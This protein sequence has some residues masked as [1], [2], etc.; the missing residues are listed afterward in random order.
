MKLSC[1]IKMSDVFNVDRLVP[2][3]DNSS[4]DDTN[5]R[6]NS[7]QPKEDEN[8]MEKFENESLIDQKARFNRSR[9]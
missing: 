8:F 7:L 1:H 5:L 4:D 6:E 3:I 9:E 2:Y